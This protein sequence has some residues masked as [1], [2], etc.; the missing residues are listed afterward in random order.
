M[1][2][3]AALVAAIR[4]GAGARLLDIL[5]RDD[6]V[7]DGELLLDREVHQP[8]RALPA[9]IVVVRGLAPDHAAQRHVTVVGLALLGRC[10]R[11]RAR[12]LE[13]A[14]HDDPLRLRAV[15]R[16]LL[17]GALDE[18][19]GDVGVVARLHDEDARALDARDRRPGGRI[20]RPCR[21]DQTFARPGT[22]FWATIV[23]PK[24]SRAT[25][26]FCELLSSTISFTP[27]SISI[28]APTP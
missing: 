23:R 16:N 12:D 4:V 7:A 15:L 13:G 17:F 8:A 3:I 2:G 10:Q 11:D 18:R 25:T 19:I 22:G 1:G 28:W 14:R 24:P 20:F 6:A 27:R 26:L 21:H 9:D 5:D